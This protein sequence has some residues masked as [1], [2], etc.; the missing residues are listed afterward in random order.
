MHV[1]ALQRLKEQQIV[2]EIILEAS[3]LLA[4]ATSMLV[5]LPVFPLLQRSFKTEVTCNLQ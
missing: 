4:A 2:K 3:R 1:K 5:S